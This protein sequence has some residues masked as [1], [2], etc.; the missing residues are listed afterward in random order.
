VPNFYFPH[1]KITVGAQL[2]FTAKIK[3][4]KTFMA[5]QLLSI[6]ENKSWGYKNQ[7]QA[8]SKELWSQA[9]P[10]YNAYWVSP[11]DMGRFTGKLSASSSPMGPLCDHSRAESGY[12]N[13]RAIVLGIEAAHRFLIF[14][15]SLKIQ[16]T[17]QLKNQFLRFSIV[18]NWF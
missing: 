3:V 13:D 6:L 17:G 7:F 12:P 18:F 15:N 2:I 11:L 1:E 9:I 4:V 5:S 16:N 8:N 14:R 10:S